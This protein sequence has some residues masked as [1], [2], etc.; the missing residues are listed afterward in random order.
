MVVEAWERGCISHS[1]W[2]LEAC[3]EE[4]QTSLR[5]WNKTT[6]GHVGKQVTDLRKK[7][8]MLEAMKCNATNMEEIHATKV[9]LNRWLG[10]EE[11]MWRQRSRN[12][13]LKA[14]DR[15][16]TFFHTKGSNRFQR[17]TIS[18]IM[19]ANNGWR[20]D[21]DQIGQKFVSYLRS[22]SLPHGR[23]WNKR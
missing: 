23:R 4:F 20:E 18:R 15:N 5:D 19:D 9:E 21:G 6:F 1:Q 11:E 3:L 8:Q 13:W 7:L 17:N 12:N 10:I 16:T 2:P 14:E 22:S